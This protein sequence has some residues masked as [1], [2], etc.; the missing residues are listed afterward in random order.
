MF[1][2]WFAKQR[3]AT[4]V[5]GICALHRDIVLNHLF[6]FLTVTQLDNFIIK[7]SKWFTANYEE[8]KKAL[9]ILKKDYNSFLD[10]SKSLKIENKEKFSI[11]KMVEVFQSYLPTIEKVERPV[12]TK[13][14][15]PK[16]NKIK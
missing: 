16:L 11:E 14:I 4:N 10:K 1:L 15:L 9:V 2:H 12:E 13:L 7:G 8:F 5:A 3:H 6:Q